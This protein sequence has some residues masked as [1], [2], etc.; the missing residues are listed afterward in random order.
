MNVLQCLTELYN[1]QDI[2]SIYRELALKILG[3]LDQMKRVTIYDIA[4]LTNSSRTTVWRLVQKLGYDSFSDFR[5]ALQSASSQYVYYNR[6]VEQR[7]NVSGEKLIL[8]LNSQIKDVGRLLT[9]MISADEIDELT[10]EISDASKVHFYLPFRTAFVY[11]FQQNLWIDGKDTE[12]QCLIPDMLAA[13]RYLNENS[14]VLISSIERAET[15]DMTR[16]FETIKEKGSKIWLTGN[17]ESRYTD[18]ADRQLMVSNDRP[19]VWLIAF[20]IFL[21]ALSE[22]YRGKFI[23]N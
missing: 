21:L 4:E 5:Y 12:Y 1:S 13:T 6:M 3:N 19:A 9:Q 20:E 18:Y 11:S 10:D 23:D 15:Q 2:D 17:A 8:D 14:I 7:K 22:R 16:V